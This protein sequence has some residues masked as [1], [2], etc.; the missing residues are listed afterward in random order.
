VSD[1]AVAYHEA[2]VASCS[3]REFLARSARGGA[4]ALLAGGLGGVLRA[5]PLGG[6]VGI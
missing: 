3:R 4:A 2:I 1:G 5:A 6:P